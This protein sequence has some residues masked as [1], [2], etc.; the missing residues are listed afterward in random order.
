MAI[1]DI[2]HF[3]VLMMENRSFDHLFGYL[4][5][6]NIDNLTSGGPFEVDGPFLPDGTVGPPAYPF[7]STGVHSDYIT[8]PDPGHEFI[9]V[10]NQIFGYGKQPPAAANM[11]GFVQNF[12]KRSSAPRPLDIMR[13]FRMLDVPVLSTLA[14]NFVV[15]DR[16]FSSV[17][18][19]TWPNRY[20]FHA[21]TSMGWVDLVSSECLDLMTGKIPFDAPTL[22][23]RVD[24][25]GRDWRVYFHNPPHASTLQSV[26]KTLDGQLDKTHWREFDPG[27]SLP[28]FAQDV[29]GGDLPF[30]T[31]IEP[32]FDMIHPNN[33]MVPDNSGHPS[34]DFKRAQELIREVYNALRSSDLWSTS[35]L[36]ILFDEHGGFYD[37]VV[38]P[39]VPAELT[40]PPKG[41]F[42]FD[43]LGP[44]VPALVISPWVKKGF[45]DHGP[46]TGDQPDP[47][48]FYDHTSVASTL[49]K[50]LGGAPLTA[51]DR[52]AKTLD[53]LFA[54][55]QRSDCPTGI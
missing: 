25:V 48:V 24:A 21:A 42:Q 22:F 7:K 15:C 47:N 43:R 32:Q 14:H 46:G 27:N 18:S 16:W 55:S 1:A 45:V 54:N 12:Q 31:F 10:T 9:D 52:N 19:S 38:P 35:A 13:C 2:E 44:R 34:G 29:G 17:P 53:H 36:I 37:H 26:A 41:A 40:Y 5:L 33:P 6:E 30:Y 51:R 4:D 49:I 11:R 3:V 8:M 23:N 20:F 28:G 50:L 39:S